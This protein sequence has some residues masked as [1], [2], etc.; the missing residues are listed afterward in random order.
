[1]L[2]ADRDQIMNRLSPEDRSDLRRILQE[3]RKERK[4]SPGKRVTAR[5]VLQSLGP[6]L[7]ADVSAA[8]EATMV[9]D[10]TGPKVGEVPPDFSLKRLES[11]ERVRLSSFKDRQPVALAFGSYT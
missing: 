2:K 6:D 5:E 8:L 3:L 7:A 1:M 11:P 4:A 9:R 10:E